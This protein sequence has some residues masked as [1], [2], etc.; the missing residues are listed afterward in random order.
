M[1]FGGCSGV[2]YIELGLYKFLPP[3]RESES[4]ELSLA[5]ETSESDIALPRVREWNAWVFKIVASWRL[6]TGVVHEY[7]KHSRPVG[8]Q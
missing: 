5:E 7:T 6:H 1:I 4:G 3:V 2:A 8:K